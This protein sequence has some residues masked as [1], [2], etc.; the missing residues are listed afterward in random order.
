MQPELARQVRQE[1][2]LPL[3]VYA[4]RAEAEQPG[5]QAPTACVNHDYQ[6]QTAY[7]KTPQSYPCR[8]PPETPT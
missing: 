4:V 1:S 7:A 2:A 6:M 8:Y 5:V 3:Q